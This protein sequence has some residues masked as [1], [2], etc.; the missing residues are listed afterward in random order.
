MFIDKAT[1]A[2]AYGRRTR[3]NELQEGLD[4]LGFTYHKTGPTLKSSGH[5]KP[6]ADINADVATPHTLASALGNAAATVT[7]KL[8]SIPPPAKVCIVSAL[9]HV[10]SLGVSLNVEVLED[11]SSDHRPIVAT[12]GTPG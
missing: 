8:L 5:F 4:K 1:Y 3:L 10:Y 11:A 9:D 6:R 7:N 12:V 2:Y